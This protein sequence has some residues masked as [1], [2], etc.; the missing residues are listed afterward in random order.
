MPRLGALQGTLIHPPRS[1]RGRRLG[2][3]VVLFV[4]AAHPARAIGP[5]LLRDID[6]GGPRVPPTCPFSPCPLPEPL[7]GSGVVGVMP[8]GEGFLFA[9]DDGVHGLEPWF[10]DGSEAGTRPLADLHPGDASS[11]PLP[12]GPIGGRALFWAFGPADWGLWASDGTPRGTARVSGLCDGGSCSAPDRRAPAAVAH[13]GRLYFVA[14]DTTLGRTALYRTDGRVVE[15][16]RDPCA[17]GPPCTL[18]VAGLVEWSGSLWVV[19]RP[20]GEGVDRVLRLTGGAA[21]PVL[22]GC[23]RVDRPTV[24]ENALVFTGSCAGSS[25]NDLFS[26][27]GTQLAVRRLSG[28][29]GGAVR[30]IAPAA[31]GVYVVTGSAAALDPRREV[32]HSDGTALG[33]RWIAAFDTVREVVPLGSSLLV[34]GTPRGG[35][36]EGLWRVRADGE[37][38]AVLE[39]PLE[40]P[41]VVTGGEAFFT[42]ADADHG[43][44]LWR[45]DG[46]PEGTRLAADVNPGPGP[47]RRLGT[48]PGLPDLAVAGDRL[49]FAAYHPDY[50]VEPW[51]LPLEG[52][53]GGVPCAADDTTLCLDGRFRVTVEWRNHRGVEGRR[54]AVPHASRTGAFWFFTPGNLELVVKVLDACGSP[55][56]RFWVFAAGLTDVETTL[57]VEDLEASQSREYHNPPGS[58]FRSIQDTGAFLTCP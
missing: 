54:H 51:I 4:L 23:S 42:A 24:L 41:F 2:W 55:S 36:Q 20:S 50:G 7:Q 17:Q 57:R 58:A 46:S 45:T 43:A 10:S 34:A 15:L 3:F 48:A 27:S 8:L 11:F 26:A 25:A 22:T 5:R 14:H 6:P 1:G 28:L 9:A 21:A 12:L 33:T 47:S 39:L 32:W 53:P 31:T 38:E 19:E 56:P 29:S 44:E 35:R 49:V 40:P 13:R 37:A 30:E 16:V 18:G 52:R